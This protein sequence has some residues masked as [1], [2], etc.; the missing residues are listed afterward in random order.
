MARL[1]VFRNDV[2]DWVIAESPEDADKIC[3]EHTGNDEDDPH[4]WVALPDD[5][6]LAINDE[7][8]G[9]VE[10]TC[11]ALIAEHGRCFLASTEY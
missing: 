11:A 7:D 10:K 8:G 6:I 9:H 5:Q 4:E 1:H 3:F 2:I